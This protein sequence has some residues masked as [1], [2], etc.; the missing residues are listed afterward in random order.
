MTEWVSDWQVILLNFSLLVPIR[1]YFLYSLAVFL[2]YLLGVSDNSC[3]IKI[4][5]F[6]NLFY[7]NS[8]TEVYLGTYSVFIKKKLLV[9]ISF[10]W[11]S[12]CIMQAVE[13]DSLAKPL[14]FYIIL[15]RRWLQILWIWFCRTLFLC[16][17]RPKEDFIA[18]TGSWCWEKG[19]NG[20]GM[21]EGCM[22]HSYMSGNCEASLCLSEARICT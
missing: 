4:I 5:F 3:T 17:Y 8:H 19:Y 11:G 16:A 7:Y 18:E 22:H 14:L 1:N 13:K 2:V 20:L 9:C 15:C 6:L 21:E 10:V 12:H